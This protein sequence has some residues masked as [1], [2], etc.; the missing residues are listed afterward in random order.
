MSAF[1]LRHNPTAAMLSSWFDRMLG[2]LS[3]ESDQELTSRLQPRMDISEE[4][5]HYYISMDVP[6]LT[7]SDISIKV[8]NGAVKIE[9]ERKE[10]KK[11]KYHHS[12]RAYGKFLRSFSLPDDVDS[13]KIEAKAENGVL[14]LKLPKNKKALP[15]EIKIS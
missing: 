8:E 11:G 12:E 9:G 2:D 4:E 10:E 7:K 13:A 6:G 1:V 15:I 14:E 3:T 5:G